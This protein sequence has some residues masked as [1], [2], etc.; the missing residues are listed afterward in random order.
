MPGR[1]YRAWALASALLALA[2]FFVLPQL[3]ATVVRGA[4]E[5]GGA[6]DRAAYARGDSPWSWRFRRADDV[7]AGKAFGPASLKPADGGLALTGHGEVGL[8]LSRQADLRQL[9]QL[10]VD[11][12]S[13]AARYALSVRP[14]LTSPLVRADLPGDVLPPTISLDELAWHDAAGHPVAAPGRAAMLRLGFDL[15]DGATLL[16]RGA[17]LARTGATLPVSGVAIPG[18]LTGEALLQ[19]RDRQRSRNPLVTLGNAAAPEAVPPWRGWLAPAVYATLLAGGVFLRR[20]TTSAPAAVPAA[21]IA[22]DSAPAQAPSHAPNPATPATNLAHAALTLLGPLWFIAGL[23][24]TARPTASGIAMFAGGVAYGVFLTWIRALPHWHWRGGWRMAGWPL[25][26]IPVA[27][28]LA[29]VAGHAPAWPPVGRALL[30]VGWALFQQWLMLAVVGGLLARALPR[31]LAVLLIAL[32]F[33]L[34]HTPNGLLM[35]LC[36]VAELGWAWW[37]LHHRSLL[38]VALAHAACAVILQACLAG[39]VLR[40]LEVSARYLT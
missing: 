33:A 12:A 23:G 15:P 39:D 35:Q 27:L 5:A 38:P 28:A 7:V 18:G 8:P 13:P 16:L 21:V 11:A 3:A 6:S 24:L 40:S 1:P 31:P 17:G 29:V 25:L 30:Y 26:A 32:A 34:L 10:H 2:A 4:L 19:W 14:T 20:R 22:A 37:Y 9:D 36:F